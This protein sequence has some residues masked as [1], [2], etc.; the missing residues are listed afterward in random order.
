LLYADLSRREKGLLR[1][2]VAR[3]T[4]LSRAQIT[5]LIASYAETA[6]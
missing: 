2:Y 5:R 6:V 4:G 1:L 3:I